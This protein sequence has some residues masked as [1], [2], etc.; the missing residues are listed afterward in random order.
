MAGGVD[1][2][3]SGSAGSRQPGHPDRR[4]PQPVASSLPGINSYVLRQDLRNL[5][6][7]NEEIPGERHRSICTGFHAN[8]LAE[9]RTRTEASLL[10]ALQ[11][12]ALQLPIWSS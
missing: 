12:A 7:G 8:S 6:V 9:G 5:V 4:P 3:L 1:Q 11:I 2:T 10:E